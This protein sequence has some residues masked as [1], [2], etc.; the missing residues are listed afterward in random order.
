[1][2]SIM[3]LYG[4]LMS[5]LKFDLFGLGYI[6]GGMNGVG[7]GMGMVLI[8]GGLYKVDE[9][10]GYEGLLRESL[11]EV[12]GYDFGWCEVWVWMEWLGWEDMGGYYVVVRRDGEDFE[13]S[14]VMFKY[15]DMEVWNNYRVI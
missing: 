11:Y 2:K 7:F 13:I 12:G 6:F 5:M 9:E 8:G 3:I 4:D 10:V 14:V 15:W 1:M